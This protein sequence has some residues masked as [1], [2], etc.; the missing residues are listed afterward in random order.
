MPRHQRLEKALKKIFENVVTEISLDGPTVNPFNYFFTASD[1][2]EI[3]E[4]LK[5]NTAIQKVSMRYVQMPYTIR[6]LSVM[7][8]YIADMLST[9][10]TIKEL[11]LCTNHI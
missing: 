8:G 10:Q 6:S 7:A 2:K 9:N 5:H 3:C 4:A 1:I 11:D